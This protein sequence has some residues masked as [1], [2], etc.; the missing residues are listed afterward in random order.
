MSLRHVHAGPPNIMLE[1]TAGSHSLAA[2]AQHG[3][4]ADNTIRPDH[5]S[6]GRMVV[7]PAIRRLRVVGI[8]L[9]LLAAPFA[10]EGQ[11]AGTWQIGYLETSSP[12]SARLQLLEAFRQGYASWAIWRARTSRW[13]LDLERGDLT[14]S[15]ILPP[16]WWGSRSTFS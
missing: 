15:S 3:R 13:C 2:A 12:S 11:P 16:S 6:P 10:A 7:K 5:S 1:R 9:L 14:R 8:V 4:S